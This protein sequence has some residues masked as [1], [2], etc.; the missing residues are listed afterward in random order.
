MA[1]KPETPSQGK[2]MEAEQASVDAQDAT[3]ATS[4]Q[5]AAAAAADAPEATPTE[6]AEPQ[7]EGTAAAET[8]VDKVAAEA[9]SKGDASPKGA[10]EEASKS[11]G[12]ASKAKAKGAK[13]EKD[14]DKP[15]SKAV[16]KAATKAKAPAKPATKPSRRRRGARETGEELIVVRAHAKYVRS[17]ARKARLVCD[18]IRG[19]SV[20]EARALLAFS[21]RDVA[22]AWTKLLDSAVANAEHNHNLDGDD[23]KVLAVFADEGPTIKRFRPRA[24][25]RA[26]AIRK[27][28]SHLTIQLTPKEL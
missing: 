14:A 15:K 23:L 5:E 8:G 28:T 16:E 6:K 9:L 3:A 26:T 24:M 17:S 20:P 10:A 27:R 1:E 19:K 4:Q 12:K 2:P 13:A 21:P 25:G 11:K 22:E 18:Q 7:A